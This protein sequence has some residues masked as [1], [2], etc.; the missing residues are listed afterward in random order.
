MSCKS[1]AGARSTRVMNFEESLSREASS[2]RLFLEMEKLRLGLVRAFKAAAFGFFF[3]M[4]LV[5][6]GCVSE[7]EGIRSGALPDDLGASSSAGRAPEDDESN[8]HCEAFDILRVK[9]GRCHGT[10]LRY[11]APFALVSTQDLD[12]VDGRG[13]ARR[14][15]MASAIERGDMPPQFLELEPPVE[16]LSDDDAQRLL[17]WLRSGTAEDVTACD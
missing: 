5:A 12:P 15:R 4:S 7:P 8:A 16:A 14:E 17:S 10:P 3:S 11:G 13:V 6:P 1:G 2:V 9:C